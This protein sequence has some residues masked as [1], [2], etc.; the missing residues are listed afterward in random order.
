M[1]EPAPSGP[2][3]AIPLR[4]RG[5]VLWLLALPAVLY[6]LTPVI[7]NRIEPRLLGIPFLIAYLLVV[8]VLSGPLVALVARFD[9]AYRAGA[10]EF[11]PADENT[12]AP[13]ALS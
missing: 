10:E 5:P 12:T 4:R 11:V 3:P 6:C 2:A 8:T 7:A 13:E 9:P 1:A